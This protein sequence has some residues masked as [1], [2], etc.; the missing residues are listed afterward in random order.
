VRRIVLPL[1]LLVACQARESA[2][3]SPAARKAEAGSP[4]AGAASIDPQRLVGKWLRA[5]SDYTIDV[6][7]VGSDG[8]LDAQYLNP[9]PIHVGR[10]AWKLDGG[11]LKIAVELQD[12]G[13]PGSFY[14]L[15]YDPGADSLSGVYHHLGLNQ[16][17]E[18]VFSR[19]SGASAPKAP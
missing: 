14:T 19:I 15:A 3:S 9:N 17:F 5:D 2:Q 11:T 12:R 8:R 18:V 7:G 10:A 13:Y 1:I 6:A 16:E 4:A